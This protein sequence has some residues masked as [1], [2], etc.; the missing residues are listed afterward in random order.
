VNPVHGTLLAF[1]AF[2]ALSWGD[3]IIKA[4]GGRMS[5]FEIGVVFLLASGVATY[6]MRPAGERWRDLFK[7]RHPWLTQARAV[8]GFGAGLFGVLAF[9]TIP[10]AEAYALIFMAPFIVMLLSIALLKER[11]GWFGWAAMAAGVVGVLLVIKPGFRAVE[12]GHVSALAAAGFIACT[13]IILRRIAGN[14]KRTSLLGVP[15]LYAVVVNAILAIP[16]FSMP[17]LTDVA[18]VA[19][20]GLLGAVGQLL[21][22]RASVHAP[23]S[24]VGQAQYS[25][26]IWA[27]L[28]GALFY[29]EFPDLLAVVGLG[30]IAVAG[31]ATVAASRLIKAPPQ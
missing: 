11:I 23:A 3:G 4:V 29:R 13:V 15:P 16:G 17:T 9:T 14:E 28:I 6:F 30:V 12:L 27:V 8:T 1:A 31:L 10:F 2:G 5:V 26:L 22:L 18:L 20:A 19:V 24:T 7:M 25:Q 21:L